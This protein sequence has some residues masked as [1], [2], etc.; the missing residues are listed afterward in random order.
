MVG[1][2]AYTR[3]FGREPETFAKHRLQFHW[4]GVDYKKFS[5]QYQSQGWLKRKVFVI[6]SVAWTALIKIPF[7][8]ILTA[9]SALPLIACNREMTFFRNVFYIVRDFQELF[10]KILALFYDRMGKF[11]IEESLFHR[12]C[13]NVYTKPKKYECQV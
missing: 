10:G 12:M 2:L 9:I 1:C 7:D 6:P 8:T 13:Y 5:E 3:A 11:H 4:K